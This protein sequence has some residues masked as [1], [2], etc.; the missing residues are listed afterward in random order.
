MK[1]VELMKNL[2]DDGLRAENARLRA[3]NL[4]LKD[5]NIRQALLIREFHELEFKAKMLGITIQ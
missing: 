4:E 2:S 3:E 1:P 5:L